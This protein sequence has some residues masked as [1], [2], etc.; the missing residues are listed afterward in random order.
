[1]LESSGKTVYKRGSER[2]RQTRQAGDNG[3]RTG[4]IGLARFKD[5]NR[6]V[7]RTSRAG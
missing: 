4:K 1:M 3:P 2:C 7:H 6:T 5:D